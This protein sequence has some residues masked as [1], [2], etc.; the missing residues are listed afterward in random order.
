MYYVPNF[1]GARSYKGLIL[2]SHKGI[3]R[4]YLQSPKTRGHPAITFS[5]PLSQSS[6]CMVALSKEDLTD[7]P[8]TMEDACMPNTGDFSYHSADP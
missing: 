5:S 3:I 1:E 2:S 6:T 4:S 8:F 7:Y